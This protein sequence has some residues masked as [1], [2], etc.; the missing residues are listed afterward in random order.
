[1]QRK[2][3]L[4]KPVLRVFVSSTI[5]NLEE[6]RETLF[7]VILTSG[8][9]PIAAEYFTASG[10]PSLEVIDASLENSDAVILLVGD[11]HGSKV[12]LHKIKKP[13]LRELQE[14]RDR[15]SASEALNAAVVSHTSEVACHS[16]ADSPSVVGE[17]PEGANPYEDDC[18]GLT[19]TEYEY[20]SAKLLGK[21]VIPVV[22]HDSSFSPPA[23]ALL[24]LDPEFKAFR[25]RVLEDE[26]SLL[27]PSLAAAL[28]RI[29]LSLDDV[30][31]RS[32]PPRAVG[33]LPLGDVLGAVWANSVARGVVEE[34]RTYQKL[35][36]RHSQRPTLKQAL[37]RFICN[38]VGPHMVLDADQ[39][40]RDDIK[41]KSPDA[42][43]KAH[44]TEVSLFL[45]SGSTCLYVAEQLQRSMNGKWL[46]AKI[47]TNNVLAYLHLKLKGKYVSERLNVDMVTGWPE[48]KWGA[49]YS[50][51]THTASQESSAVDEERSV[52][53]ELAIDLVAKEIMDDKKRLIVAATSALA[54]ECFGVP[55]SA[56][57]AGVN[58]GPH[59]GSYHNALFKCALIRSKQPM[60]WALDASKLA[61]E[62]IWGRCSP[63]VRATGDWEKVSEKGPMAILIAYRQES[64][65]NKSRLLQ[66][67]A[68]NEPDKA[69]A[70]LTHL[71]E[72]GELT[73]EQVLALGEEFIGWGL[74][75]Q[76]LEILP[77]ENENTQD[78][79]LL[80]VANELFAKRY[81]MTS[82][83]R[84]RS[85]PSTATE[86]LKE[87]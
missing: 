43:K 60:L 82:S 76:S 64:A 66:R 44:P 85:K 26:F 59:V 17:Q 73:R 65:S 12:G 13:R 58:P 19:F 80:L 56:D 15:D 57:G 63:V 47:L 31:N 5:K 62:F 38:V 75:W 28:P 20:L 68:W 25:D 70:E 46:K 2:Q 50:H 23:K 79:R 10:S 29:A 84:E 78:V 69:K 48:G 87:S 49:T 16:S 24:D 1:M 27:A 45:E 21:K 77:P 36:E 72:G 4:Q 51:I 34:L 54:T 6:T 41:D 18:K 83:L 55:R 86:A 53:A 39:I 9:L 40:A 37:A 7:Q 35:Y 33:L 71:L 11:V 74:N 14:L 32:D 30:L 52:E 42:D 3:P 81:K 67:D 61:Q 22:L 8:H